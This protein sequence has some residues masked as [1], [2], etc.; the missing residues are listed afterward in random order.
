VQD[1][2][3]QLLAAFEAE[4]RDHLGAI[5]AALVKA[6][7]GRAF[8]LKDAFRRAH[9]LKGAA[10]AV[11]L[12]AI[13]DL[14]HRIEAGFSNALET[15]EPLDARAIAAIE[16]GLD[17]IEAIA[18]EV[19]AGRQPADTP[20]ARAA[21]DDWLNAAPQP[22]S[23]SPRAPPAASASAPAPQAEADATDE[24]EDDE[25]D[26]APIE[27]LRVDAAQVDGLSEA[28]HRLTEGLRVDVSAEALRRL[29]GELAGLLRLVG[30]EPRRRIEA[31]RDALSLA[32]RARQR[33]IA[34]VEQQAKTVREKV[35]GLSLVPVDTVFGGFG[36]L[37]R[38]LARSERVDAEVQVT[39]LDL[40]ADRRVL[41]ALKDPVLH[42]LRNVL[43]HAVEPSSRRVAQGKPERLQ[44]TLDFRADG[45]RLAISVRDDGRGPD[46]ARLEAVAIE[47][48]LLPP[49][50]PGAGPPPEDRLLALAFEPQVSTARNVDRLAGRGMGLSVAAEAARKL[51]GHVALRSAR[52]WG[53]EVLISA[54]LIS[55]RQ[56]LLF[57]R[58]GAQDYGLPTHAV[59][60]LLRLP[61]AAIENVEGRPATRVT[62]QGRDVTVPLIALTAVLNG[63]PE[64]LP[65][66][67]GHVK[68]VLLRAGPR[69][70]AMAVDA[71]LDVHTANVETAP[72][73]GAREALVGGAVLH[74]GERPALALNPEALVERW[75]RG[76]AHVSGGR[77]G[78]AELRPAVER[79]PTTIL[80]VDD[81]ITTRTL[82]KSILEAQGY[83][84]L[85]SVDGL[86]ALSTLRA[87]DAMVDLVIAD[88]EMPRMDGFGLLGAIKTDPRLAGIP[89]VLMTSRADEAD[90]RKGLELGASAYLTKQ[91][92]DQRDLLAAIGGLL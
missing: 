19:A 62:R 27:Y 71:F 68:A 84:V 54:P 39:G 10:R 55:S 90:V 65:V 83:R 40:Q 29:D 28:M 67:D 89:V 30:P 20:A 9:S 36:R 63:A 5:R 23:E 3:A 44:V 8:D 46:Y 79:P 31:A 24:A 43:T 88:V 61:V 25:A 33:A 87:G 13:E 45:G 81:S 76:Q 73:S 91:T 64:P 15:E 51:R 69:L 80:V 57:A 70:C 18:S 17:A 4:H 86:D 2:R 32:R 12:P 72:A 48:G 82:E 7:H 1:I 56:S 78:L 58:A 11:D 92:F 26:A 35:D 14:A 16:L 49:R 50:P 38:E 77:F 37:F 59:E 34:A 60:G 66:E 42:V 6:A 53:A 85:L 22:A 75:L 52:P 21:L 74:G 41:Q 47:R